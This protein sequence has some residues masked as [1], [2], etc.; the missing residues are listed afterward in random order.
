MKFYLSKSTYN[1]VIN[2]VFKNSWQLITDVKSLNKINQYPFY[3]L[4]GSIN[5]PMILIKQN[6]ILMNRLTNKVGDIAL[7][8]AV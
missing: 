8:N 5:E 4:P 2:K 6:E 1:N 3:F 7:S